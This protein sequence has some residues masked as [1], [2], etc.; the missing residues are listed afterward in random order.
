MARRSTLLVGGFGV[1]SRV[2]RPLA[3]DLGGRI[4]PTGL[5]IG[6]GE[7]EAQKVVDAIDGA[8]GDVVL[9]G[10]SRGGQLARVAAA[11]RPDR[12]ALLV[13]VATPAAI[14]PPN[15]WGVPL[16]AAALRRVPSPIALDCAT[17]DCCVAFRADLAR[18]VG[19]AWTAIWSRAD[20]IV[21]P[22]EARHEGATHVEVPSGHM[23]AV[24]SDASR[25][26]I[27]EVVRRSS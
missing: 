21:P 25:R 5:T 16:M 23:G 2:L 19:V 7:V 10:H 11:R 15:R 13:C 18:P 3:R 14:G 4:V 6:C 26:V 12:V 9:V 8:A 27:V 17:A 1:P 24:V 20:R 22:D